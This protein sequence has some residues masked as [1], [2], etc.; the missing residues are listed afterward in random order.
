MK[1]APGLKWEEVTPEEITTATEVI[2]P[3]LA[4]ALSSSLM[5]IALI[6]TLGEI[7]IASLVF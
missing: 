4:S 7:M 1:D 2:N 3:E 6:I 5:M